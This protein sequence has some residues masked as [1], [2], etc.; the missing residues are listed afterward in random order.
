[1]RHFGIWYTVV[2]FKEFLIKIALNFKYYV[3]WEIVV[4][5][6]VV[7][8]L[9]NVTEGFGKKKVSLIVAI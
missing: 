8:I 5:W 7:V 1:M 9:I 6:I 3:E 2:T 4:P